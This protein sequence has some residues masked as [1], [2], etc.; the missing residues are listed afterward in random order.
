MNH[1]NI[2]A[3]AFYL[4]QF[5]P[6]KENDEFWGKGFTEWTNVTQAKPRYEG[7]YQPHLPS[8][9]GFYDLRLKEARLSQEEYAKIYGIE[10][11]CY[12]H[13]WFQGKKVLSEPLERK[14]ANSDE[15]LPFMICWANEN[16]TRNWDGQNNQILL[17]Q[18]YSE[19]DDVVHFQEFLRYF[20]DKRYMTVDQKPV[21]LIYR[22][23]LFPDISKTAQ[24]WRKLAIENGL[25]GLYLMAVKGI[26]Q[27]VDSPEKIGF[28]ALVDFQ[29][30]FSVSYQKKRATLI[31]R[32]IFKL[33]GKRHELDFNNM[34]E[35]DELVSKC[36]QM[37]WPQTKFYPCIS[38]SWDNSARRKTGATIFDGA[39]PQKYY[40]W[41]RQVI[42]RFKPYS[43]DENFI[44]INAWN[45][46]AEGNHLEPCR[47]WG[48]K[49]L[50]YTAL[51]LDE[52]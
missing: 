35:Y 47:K 41:L 14:L 13:Y 36:L 48:R 11:F 3:V 17:E 51:A 30:D 37:N 21:L 26:N 31:E 34:Y 4:P 39:T 2:R 50:E 9:F 45:E 46:W 15:S 5:H 52:K 27:V 23:S 6:I 28:D 20:K 42:K 40:A 33:S 32:I 19:E 29:P 43:K 22:T 7:H 1:K 24:L 10:G 12:Y 49:Y 16:W 25:P 8:D 44:F 38:P 18:K